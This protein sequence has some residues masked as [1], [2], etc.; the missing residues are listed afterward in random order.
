MFYTGTLGGLGIKSGK[1]RMLMIILPQLLRHIK[2]PHN[3][4][5]LAKW[6][7]KRIVLISRHETRQNVLAWWP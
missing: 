6:H 3:L 4:H 1:K 7:L 2:T 5:N